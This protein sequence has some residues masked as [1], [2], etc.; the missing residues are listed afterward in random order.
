M[1]GLNSSNMAR[2]RSGWNASFESALTAERPQQLDDLLRVPLPLARSSAVA[3]PVQGIA[4]LHVCL[5]LLPQFDAPGDRLGV[6]G[7]E[8]IPAS[9]RIYQFKNNV[10]PT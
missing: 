2:L 8:S 1:S 5:A 7:I 6:A 9:K 3:E 4:D 10:L